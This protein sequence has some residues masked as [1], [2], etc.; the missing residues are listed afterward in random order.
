MQPLHHCP[1]CGSLT[2]GTTDEGGRDFKCCLVCFSRMEETAAEASRPVR[3][4]DP[5]D[6]D[7]RNI[8]MHSGAARDSQPRVLD[9]SQD[10]IPTEI[11]T[12]EIDAYIEDA[13]MLV[14]VKLIED[15]ILPVRATD[16]S[17]G[18]DLFAAK[19]TILPPMAR[20][21][22]PCGIAIALPFG[23]EAQVRPRSGL[24]LH[25]GITVLNSPGTID[26]DYHDEIHAILFNA[27]NETFEVKKGMRIAQLVF[28]SVQ[29]PELRPV[30]ELPGS[31]HRGF[32]STGV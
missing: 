7:N 32:G 31:S 19:P 21:A 4:R 8:G 1:F 3:R 30:P 15:G 10:I 23:I 13:Q 6:S 9:T 16:G 29:V 12:P 22:V 24:A 17:H 14:R 11:A 18:Y 5:D 28:C 20:Q 25:H 2:Y 26:A 27:G